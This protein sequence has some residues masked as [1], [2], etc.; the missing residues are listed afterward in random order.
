MYTELECPIA[1]VLNHEKYILVP[2]VQE[3]EERLSNFVGVKHTTSCSFGTDALLL[4]LMALGVGSEDAII[5]FSFTFVATVEVTSL[6]KSCICGYGFQNFQ[7]RSF[8]N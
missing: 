1:F 4:K 3:L 5:T 8:Q 7:Y 2:E 6:L